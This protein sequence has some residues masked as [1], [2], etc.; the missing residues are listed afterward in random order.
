MLW[1]YNRAGRW[2]SYEVC[3]T[4]DGKGY[5]MKRR[6]EDGEEEFER[7]STLEQLN[8]RIEQLELELLRDGWSLAGGIRH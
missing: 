8:R 6:H 4:H 3:Q 7:F 5:E 1:T 2:T